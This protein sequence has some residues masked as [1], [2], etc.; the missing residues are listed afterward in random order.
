MS[1]FSSLGFLTGWLCLVIIS[2]AATRLMIK[3]R[4]L[5]IPNA[6]SSHATAVPSAGGVGIYLTVILGLGV[7]SFLYAESDF[8]SLIFFILVG[9]SILALG[10]F[11]DD[12]ELASGF[13]AKLGFQI[14]GS[15]VV[16]IG[17][18]KFD[19]IYL[20]FF[21]VIEFGWAGYPL[22][23]IWIIGMTNV[24][25]FMD[26]LDGIA[27][28]CTAIAMTFLSVIFLSIGSFDLAIFSAI[29]TAS[30]LGFL[31]FNFPKAR[32]FMGDCGSQFLGFLVGVT[33]ILLAGTTNDGAL[34]FIVPLLF[35]H[36][37]FDTICTFIRRW[38]R[39]EN[40]TQGH[41]SHLYQLLNRLGYSHQF[42]ST[43]H[44]LF[45]VV[46]GISALFVLTLSV[47]LRMGIFVPVGV[48]LFIYLVL[49]T[50]TSDKSH[51]K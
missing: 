6:R 48:I 7:F 43:L 14:L 27:G 45:S 25:N 2:A 22:S 31:F 11:L 26:G 18:I 1:T 9:G 20:P 4:V 38:R 29:V 3:F 41:R 17:G 23:L 5:A 24:L 42:V 34:W 21:G 40:V 33:A 12:I 51:L 46:V 37:L 30:S 8:R 19:S 39:G 44:F 16:L 10:G 47:D 32:I 13:R 50:R 35:V 36:F 28:G 15:L 49:V